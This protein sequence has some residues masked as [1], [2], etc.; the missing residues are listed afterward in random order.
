MVLSD[1]DLEK[2]VAEIEDVEKLATVQSDSDVFHRWQGMA[3]VHERAVDADGE[4]C[5]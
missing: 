4:I 2:C 5:A 3:V 1:F